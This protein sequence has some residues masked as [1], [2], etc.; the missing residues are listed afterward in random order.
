MNSGPVV[1]GD[2]PMN[3][4]RIA[5][6]QKAWDDGAWVREA[7]LAHAAKKAAQPQAAE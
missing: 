3:R 4:Q 6:R 1:K 2:G 5:A 7:A